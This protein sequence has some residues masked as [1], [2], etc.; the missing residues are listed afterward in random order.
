M[1]F[2]G[3]LPQGEV[4]L[5][6]PAVCQRVGMSRAWIYTNIRTGGDFPRPIKTGVRASVWLQSEV[7]AWLAERAS[8]RSDRPT[9]A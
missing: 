5:K 4:G 2:T 6:L 9:A 1:S 7:D 8:K 3:S